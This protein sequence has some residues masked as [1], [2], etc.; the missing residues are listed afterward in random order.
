MLTVNVVICAGQLPLLTA[1][2]HDHQYTVANSITNKP[3]L[4]FDFWDVHFYTFSE[5]YSNA[6]DYCYNWRNGQRPMQITAVIEDD[7]VKLH[8]CPCI[9][10]AYL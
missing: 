7:V 2:V 9:L 3:H 10:L 8:K 4:D 6:I 1:S 5:T